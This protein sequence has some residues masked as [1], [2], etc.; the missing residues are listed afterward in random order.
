MC[1]RFSFFSFFAAKLSLLVIA[2]SCPC[3]L[4]LVGG[5]AHACLFHDIFLFSFCFMFYFVWGCCGVYLTYVVSS[6]FFFLSIFL[7]FFLTCTCAFALLLLYINIYTLLV[8]FFFHGIMDMDIIGV[9]MG[10]E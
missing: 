9:W 7:S 5:V 8:S 4:L 6:F 1:V 3:L 2:C 10:S